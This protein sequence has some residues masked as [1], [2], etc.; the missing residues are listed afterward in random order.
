MGHGCISPG[1]RV[2]GKGD[3]ENDDTG[4]SDKMSLQQTE[5]SD[6][7]P[8]GLVGLLLPPSAYGLPPSTQAP[9]HGATAVP[10]VHP[11]LPPLDF[12]K[13][14]PLT[15]VP[16]PPYLPVRGFPLLPR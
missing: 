9:S 15:Q 14:V 2:L 6:L 3:G 10:Q 8:Q 11:A 4:K 7:Q 1:R 13:A 16:F 5:Q 12:A